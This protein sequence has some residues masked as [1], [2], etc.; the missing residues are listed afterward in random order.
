MLWRAR[1]LRLPTDIS[2][3]H[4]GLAVLPT[5]PGS[6]EGRRVHLGAQGVSAVV[7]HQQ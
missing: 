2:R 5:D 1:T 3:V 6:A 4:A 7:Q